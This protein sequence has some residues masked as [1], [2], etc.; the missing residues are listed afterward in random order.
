MQ[1]IYFDM[2]GNPYFKPDNYPIS[3][4][5]SVYSLIYIKS[6]DACLVISPMPHINPIFFKMAGGGLENNE[7]YIEAIN[8]ELI[9]ET[10]YGL[11]DE[12]HLIKKIEY[13]F[14]FKP[15]SLDL[16][17][18]KQKNTFLLYEIETIECSPYQTLRWHS[19]KENILCS[20]IPLSFFKENF[21]SMHFMHKAAFKDFIEFIDKTK[22]MYLENSEYFS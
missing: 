22:I 2:V 15:M 13:S 8:R 21:D 18:I 5:S 9:E 19:Q 3:D 11:S 16:K 12:F 4:R 7:N 17:Y 6:I 20:I 1:E 14:N 10:D